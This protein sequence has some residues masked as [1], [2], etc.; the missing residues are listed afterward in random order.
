[1]ALNFPIYGGVCLI[2]EDMLEELQKYKWHV[3]SN[4]YARANFSKRGF[5]LMHQ[6]VLKDVKPPLIR[7]HINRNK[8]DNRRENLR[9]T[10]LRGQGLNNGRIPKGYYWREA[11]QAWVVRFTINR[12]LKYFGQYYNEEAAKQ[13]AESVYKTLIQKAYAD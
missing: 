1:M 6:L 8:L 3:T 13:K 11:R 4:G 2:D 7:D 12:Q 10:S 5:V 9:A